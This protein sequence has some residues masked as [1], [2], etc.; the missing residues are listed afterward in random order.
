MHDDDF[1]PIRRLS[2]CIRIIKRTSPLW[3]V[4]AGCMT[5]NAATGDGR[6]RVD[7]SSSGVYTYYVVREYTIHIHIYIHYLSVYT[8][9]IHARGAFRHAISRSSSPD[10]S[11][12][13]IILSR[14]RRRAIARRMCS[15]CLLRRWR[16]KVCV[17]LLCLS[18][19][20]VFY[21]ISVR[22]VCVRV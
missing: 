21:N 12:N 10:Q 7:P 22:S 4:Y 2:I 20:Y 16:C 3:I 14:G 8:M 17:L 13:T 1:G 6:Y 19:A 15:A 18:Y 9:H 5:V 11:R